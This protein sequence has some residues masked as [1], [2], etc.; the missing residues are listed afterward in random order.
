MDS[1]TQSPIQSRLA[2]ARYLATVEGNARLCRDHYMLRLRLPDGFPQSRPGQFIQIGCR[3]PDDAATSGA[4]DARVQGGEL[5]W[6]PDAPPRPRQLELC[7]RTALLRRPFS[8]AGRGDDERGAWLEILHRV[9]G[10]GTN[11]LA[12][13]E[14]GD[15]VDLIGPLG[16]AFAIPQD[17]SIGLLVGGGVGLPPM[18]YLAESLRAAGWSGI[19]FIGA[20]TRD[21]LPVRVEADAPP[22]TTGVPSRS[23]IDFASH[24]FDSVVTTDD[25][26]LGMPGR[27]TAGLGRCLDTMGD[28]ERKQAVIYTCGPSPMMRAV[29]MLAE[30]H[31]VDCQVCLEQA[32]ACGMGTC[33]SCIVRI[34]EVDTPHGET[35]DGQP[36]RYRLACTDGPVFAA[37]QVIW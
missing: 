26:S 8:L 22:S 20:L 7:E 31:G 10:V 36:W 12:A 17:R 16:N 15:A 4:S 18:F 25:G 6:S 33:Q 28:D 24:G 30:T 3:A 9:V 35:P 19:G 5:T 27:I 1:S 2:R 11:W 21:L 37:G 29:A 34:A 23:V 14:Q 32:M 13:L